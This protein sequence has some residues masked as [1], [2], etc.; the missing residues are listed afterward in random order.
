MDGKNTNLDYGW[1]EYDGFTFRFRP[2]A[3]IKN[4]NE[5]DPLP[6]DAGDLQERLGKPCLTNE[7]WRRLQPGYFTVTWSGIMHLLHIVVV[8]LRHLDL[9][10][11]FAVELNFAYFNFQLEPGE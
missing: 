1:K 10:H 4:M 9:L 8:I 5:L 11:F 3:W 6:L 2:P 7:V